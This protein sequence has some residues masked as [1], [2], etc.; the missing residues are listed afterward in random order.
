MYESEEHNCLKNR[1]HLV[2]VIWISFDREWVFMQTKNHRDCALCFSP[3]TR[4]RTWKRNVSYTIIFFLEKAKPETFPLLVQLIFA[5]ETSGKDKFFSLFIRS[6][7]LVWC[8]EWKLFT[9]NITFYIKHFK[10]YAHYHVIS[11]IFKQ[12]SKLIE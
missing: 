4:K 2:L 9:T 5:Y 8:Y 3:E 12:N 10:Y 11:V 6:K 1:N 7:N